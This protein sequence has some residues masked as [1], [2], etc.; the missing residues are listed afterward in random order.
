MTPGPSNAL[1]AARSGSLRRALA[2]H[3]NTTSPLS[4]PPWSDCLPREELQITARRAADLVG[5]PSSV[6]DRAHRSEWWLWR[7]VARPLGQLLACPAHGRT[8]P[9]GGGT[10]VGDRGVQG[11]LPEVIGLSPGDLVEQIRLAAPARRTGAS[12]AAVRGMCARAGTA[13]GSP[14]RAAALPGWPRTSRARRR[15]SGGRP[16]PG[17]CSCADAGPQARS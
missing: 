8:G 7:W 6:G 14:P 13:A 10:D 11:V 15:P 1:Y 2:M 9:V 17:R 4:A 12:G 5:N 16:R 3:K